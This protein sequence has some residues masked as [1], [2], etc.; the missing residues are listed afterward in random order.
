MSS[1]RTD[2][3]N[4]AKDF[5]AEHLK[6]DIIDNLVRDYETPEM[7][8]G[9]PGTEEY[10]YQY[11]D[12]EYRPREAVNLLEELD[13]YEET[14]RG[15]I[16]EGDWR[17]QLSATAAF[18]YRNAVVSFINDLLGEINQIDFETIDDEVVEVL[19]KQ[20][21]EGL[22]TIEGEDKVWFEEDEADYIRSA[23]EEE[24]NEY[25]REELESQINGILKREA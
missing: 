18:T 15:I 1:Y 20:N 16:G 4:G 25:I 8:Y 5:I 24:Y 13:D 7:L 6:E 3:M 17:D 11:S 14:D 19:K 9:Y 22:K 2:A 10:T 23:F 12:T 21:A